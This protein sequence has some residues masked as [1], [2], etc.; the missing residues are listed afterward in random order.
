ML[1]FFA[2]IESTALVLHEEMAQRYGK[3]SDGELDALTD[4][5]A[6]IG[7]SASIIDLLNKDR[8]NE[9]FKAYKRM[10]KIAKANKQFA[11]REKLLK[12]MILKFL[13]RGHNKNESF[14][15]FLK[16]L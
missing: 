1:R 14:S 7:F 10:N 4:W 6:A 13:A 15:L 12:P 2:S 3:M 8:F 11:Q 16:E 9:A 5:S